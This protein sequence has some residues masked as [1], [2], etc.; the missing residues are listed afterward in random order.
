MLNDDV[1]GRV[2]HQ[3]RT[4]LTGDSP[5]ASNNLGLLAAG[6]NAVSFLEKRD[7]F[8]APLPHRVV[9]GRGVSY[10]VSHRVSQILMS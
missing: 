9:P 2:H 6:G 10:L 1:T 3:D 7:A 5:L 8:R 4:L